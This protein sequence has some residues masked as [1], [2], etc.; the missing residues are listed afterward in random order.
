SLRVRP[1]VTIKCGS[2]SRSAIF[3]DAANPRFGPRAAML[4]PN[5]CCVRC[6][7]AAAGLLLGLSS[8]CTRPAGPPSAA[9]AAAAMAA[10][11]PTVTITLPVEKRVRDYED[12]TGRTEAVESV[13]VRARVTGFLQSTGFVDGDEI[14]EQEVRDG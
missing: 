12:F 8:G 5:H 11:P 7:A 14:S 4:K 9:K 6:L 2:R 3:A 1:S 10:E 13:D